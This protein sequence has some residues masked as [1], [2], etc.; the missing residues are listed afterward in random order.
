MIEILIVA[1]GRGVLSWCLRKYFLKHQIQSSR[2]FPNC[3]KP[4]R[5]D[6]T[7]ATWLKPGDGCRLWW[8]LWL[9]CKCEEPVQKKSTRR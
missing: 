1:A 7:L 4:F 2:L 5:L 9:F 3:A 6:K 8:G